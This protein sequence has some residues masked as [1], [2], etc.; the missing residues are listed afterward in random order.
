MALSLLFPAPAR[1][2]PAMAHRQGCFRSWKSAAII[3]PAHTTT[4]HAVDGAPDLVRRCIPCRAFALLT[5]AAIE[6]AEYWNPALTSTIPSSGAAPL[7]LLASL[8]QQRL[9]VLQQ[10]QLLA[11]AALPAPTLEVALDGGALFEWKAAAE[12][13]TGAGQ[14]HAHDANATQGRADL[15]QHVLPANNPFIQRLSGLLGDGSRLFI[16][17]LPA[18]NDVH[19]AVER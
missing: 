14:W 4:P 8:S 2:N 5:P 11:A 19:W 15:L 9:Y 12:N 17:H 13:T 6:Q 10:G 3:D 18:V 1:A 16:S 7:S